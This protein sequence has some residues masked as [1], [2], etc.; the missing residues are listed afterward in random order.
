L[1]HAAS[2]FEEGLDILDELLFVKLILGLALGGIEFLITRL[3]KFFGI[4][5]D[6]NLPPGSSCKRA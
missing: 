5:K 1:E 4:F 2:L 3:V 6:L